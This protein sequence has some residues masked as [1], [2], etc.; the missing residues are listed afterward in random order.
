MG[1]KYGLSFSWKRATGLSGIKGKLSRSMGVP[2]TRQGRQRK[3][4][5]M[6]GCVIIVGIVVLSLTVVA[7]VLLGAHP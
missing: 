5:R 4:G 3:T 1:R 7:C 2:L 6:A